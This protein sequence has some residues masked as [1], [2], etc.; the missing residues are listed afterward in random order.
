MNSFLRLP[1][2]IGNCCSGVKVG[3]L[4]GVLL[5]VRGILLS[6]LVVVCSVAKNSSCRIR[7][8]EGL[9]QL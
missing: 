1:C 6:A 2:A 3:G 9:P 4:S 7:S 8:F 5:A